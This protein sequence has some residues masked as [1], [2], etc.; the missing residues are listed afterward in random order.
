VNYHV[1]WKSRGDSR[2]AP[3]LII[4]V[5]NAYRGDDAAGLIVARGLKGRLPDHV[6][7]L[8]EGGEGTTLLESWKDAEVVILIDAVHSGGE[9]GT[10]YRFDAHAQAVPANFFHY[11]T[12][13]FGVAEAIELA[14]A[15][16]RLPPCLVVYGI[17][18]KNFRPP[19]PNPLPRTS[20]EGAGGW[21]LSPEVEEA[22]REVVER[23]VELVSQSCSRVVV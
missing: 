7:I 4:G 19:P 8:E 10:L 2:I 22:V 13:A 3:T 21:G 1:N 12:H 14:R 5:G 23:V 11:S 20:G 16:D 6:T 17:E 9:P 18:G 15:L